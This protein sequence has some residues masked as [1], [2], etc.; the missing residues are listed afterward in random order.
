LIREKQELPGMVEFICENSI[1]AVYNV[2]GVLYQMLASAPHAACPLKF[3]LYKVNF[4]IYYILSAVAQL[5]E[6]LSY[7][8]AGRGFDS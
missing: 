2:M 6:A 1:D 3:I 4:I 7:K 8:P 5:V